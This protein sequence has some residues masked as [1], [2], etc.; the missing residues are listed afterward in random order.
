MNRICT[1]LLLLVAFQ[2]SMAQEK[3]KKLTLNE[4]IDLASSQSLDAFRQ[5]NMYLSSYWEF[6]YYKSDKLPQFLVGANPLSY[7][8]SIRQDYIPQD[9]SWQ[10]SQQKNITSSASLKMTQNVALT[11]GSFSASSDIGMVRNFLGDQQSMFS[12][13]MISL[14]YKQKL[15]GYNSMRWK[16]KIEPLK[17]ETAKKQFIQSKE[18]IAVK[19]T[20]KF[21]VLVD[22]QIEINIAKTNLANADTLYQIGKGRYQVGT[23]TQDELLNF[24][25]NLMNARIALTRA[26]QGLLRARSD[27]NSFLGLEKNAIL[28]CSLPTSISSALQIDV[29]KAIQKSMSNNPSILSQQRRI[30]EQDSN[31]KLVMSQNGLSAD[32]SALAGL[33]QKSTSLAESYQNPNQFQNIALVGLSVPIVDWGKRKGQL[34]MAKS[35][36]EVVINSVKQE[37]IDFEQSVMMNVLEFNLQSEQV[38]NSAK[39]DTIAQMGFDVTMRRFK[40]GKLDVTKLN[41]ARN[42]LENARRAYINSLRKYWLSYYQIR[43][44]ALF[45]FEK[46]IDLIADFEKILNQ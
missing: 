25:L 40:I 21:F 3:A 8:N 37:R 22:A 44:L 18:D 33:N 27:L 42:D 14:G 17:F 13:N 9:Q 38:L 11:G 5:Q 45:D 24:E 6:K 31:V 29:E 30:L 35:N 7:N 46:N 36:R 15:N 20:T 43:G 28:D 10:Y 32:I 2:I 19:T 39:A 1:I 12:S 4:A 41:L 23:V 26:N 34:L 16:A